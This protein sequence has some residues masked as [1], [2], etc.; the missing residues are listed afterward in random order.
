MIDLDSQDNKRTRRLISKLNKIRH[1]QDRKIDILCNDMISAHRD[2]V[3]QLSS[4][5]FTVDFYESILGQNDLGGLLNTAAE[6]IKEYVA[7][8]NVAIFLLE[9]EGFELHIVDQERPIDIDADSLESY[10]TPEVVRNICRSNRVNSLKDM[11]EMGLV[12]NVSDLSRI[13]AAAVPLGR[14]G[15]GIGFILI[16]RGADKPLGCNDF[17]KLTTIQSGLCKTIESCQA[18][19]HRDS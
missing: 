3:K 9:S 13:S 11:F 8:C 4:L 19:T 10:F 6:R 16:Y 1:T 5:N 12:G 15:S 18:L 7:D 14:F 17:E 2:F